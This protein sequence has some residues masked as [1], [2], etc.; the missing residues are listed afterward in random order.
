MTEIKTRIIRNAKELAEFAK[1]AQ[2]SGKTIGLVPTMGY[3]HEGHL[4]LIRAAREKADVVIVSDFVNPT[5][6]GP[7]ED[8]ATYPRDEAADLA[9]VQSCNAD[10]LF[11]PTVD[12]LY[13]NGQDSTWVEVM[14][15]GKILCGASRP[16]HFRGVATVVTKLLL[17]SRADY[18]F[19]GEKDYQQ[20]TILRRMVE[21]IGCQTEIIG[22]PLVRESDGLALSSRNV[23]LS[24]DAR[25]Q[26][27]SLSRG[28]R[29]ARDLFHTG[30][31]DAKKLAD[32]TRS[33][34][35]AQPD[36]QIEYITLAHPDT[37]EIYTD[38]VPDKVIML[39]AVRV[40]GVRLIDNMKLW[41]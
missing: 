40:G 12:T 1:Q 19:F 34:I 16:G 11:I 15:M 26:A 13:P 17:L 27:L 41:C 24:E 18:A 2:R 37:L 21:D 4:S 6:F 3:L 14:N 9:K 7:K 32:E 8:Y 35:A 5:Q 25:K 20:L 36:A 10:V 31:R 29:K 33:E 23:R 30:C 28:L 22:M 38:S 39:I